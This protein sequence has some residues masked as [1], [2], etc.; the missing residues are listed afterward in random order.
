MDRFLSDNLTLLLPR[1]KESPKTDSAQGGADGKEPEV[2]RVGERFFVHKAVVDEGFGRVPTATVGAFSAAAGDIMTMEQLNGLLGLRAA[3]EMRA[4][5]KSAG[6]AETVCTRW[7]T[8][9]VTQVKHL[10]RVNAHYAVGTNAIEAG[11]GVCG[12]EFVIQPELAYL[13]CRRSRLSFV[14]M[15]AKDVLGTLLKAVLPEGGYLFSVADQDK[16]EA[17]SER[18]H[19]TQ[20]DETDYEFF[21]R[22][23]ASC[24]LTYCYR[25]PKQ[26]AEA[27]ALTVP[28][29][30]VIGGTPP[31]AAVSDIA[32]ES[33]TKTESGET[34]RV[35][36]FTLLH[37]VADADM[38]APWR[39]EGWRMA[40]AQGVKECAVSF[41]DAVGTK[42]EGRSNLGGDKG[43]EYPQESDDCVARFNHVPFDNL[44]AADISSA[45]GWYL[46]DLNRGADVW[47]GTADRLEV[48]PGTKLTVRGFY[49]SS[50]KAG[51]IPNMLVVDARTTVVSD[52]PEGVIEGG[53]VQGVRRLAVEVRCVDTASKR[54]DCCSL[55]VG[56]LG[57]AAVFGRRDPVGSKVT[58]IQEYRAGTGIGT[59]VSTTTVLD[60]DVKDAAE[61]VRDEGTVF[62][63]SQTTFVQAT[64][65]D[66][67]GSFP[68]KNAAG[69]LR[70]RTVT[71][72]TGAGAATEAKS[73]V[74]YEFYA[75][76]DGGDA[77][78]SVMVVRFVQ[79]VGGLGQGLFRVPR[80]GD[81]ILAMR[82]SPG[83]TSVGGIN[84]LVG[85][86]PGSDMKHVKTWS[87]ERKKALVLRFDQTEGMKT[88]LCSAAA[89]KT[90]D[91]KNLLSALTADTRFD[92][93]GAFRREAKENAFSELGFYDRHTSSMTVVDPK[94]KVQAFT[95]SDPEKRGALANLQSTGDVQVS[96]ND[97]IEINA[98]NIHFGA[99][100]WKTWRST[101]DKVE[102][103][104]LEIDSISELVGRAR[105][106]VVLSVDGASA[107]VIDH[108]GVA[109]R[110][111]RWNV[112]TCFPATSSSMAVSGLRG[113]EV[114]GASVNIKG[115]LGTR[116][117]DA[118]GSSLALS[119][120]TACLTGSFVREQSK[121]VLGLLGSLA[122]TAG[123]AVAFPSINAIFGTGD[124]ATSSTFSRGGPVVS[125]VLDVVFALGFKEVY[126]ESDKLT[127]IRFISVLRAITAL[128]RA[129]PM[130]IQP[131][132]TEYKWEKKLSSGLVASDVI[133]LLSMLSSLALWMIAFI[134]LTCKNVTKRNAAVSLKS[135]GLWINAPEE[136]NFTVRHFTGN[137]A[138]AGRETKVEEFGDAD[139]KRNNIDIESESDFDLELK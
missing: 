102:D 122:G 60:D 81:R 8:G 120:G 124:P 119:A 77:G 73:D 11:T 132:M 75:R 23:L 32:P 7:M 91:E 108:D 35:L 138:T 78:H 86:L 82:F 6:T 137:A 111:T 80:P 93:D 36:S 88:S 104:K 39:M 70:R 116:F 85:Y 4:L 19:F 20:G 110:S 44:R 131:M 139:S 40:Y 127:A 105:R 54:S 123:S 37:P 14:D 113:V 22:V 47:S 129:A 96:A 114:V 53:G 63:H 133:C 43:K 45:A 62:G 125:G 112:M 57:N 100:G 1:T 42:L 48:R 84:Y 15:S 16:S 3:V 101:S 117:T 130:V 97:R 49:D 12:Y 58:T 30:Y 107:L 95:E 41:G 90:E 18:R 68:T 52:I 59:T 92:A 51:D 38:D 28:V 55:P 29:L 56:R 25:M 121:T 71:V 76:P 50:V 98:R 136:Q 13:Q 87:D 89:S 61:V 33:T 134:A 21:V 46:K 66:A 83:G 128:I 10:G 26:S 9:V 31:D 69:E 135:S 99:H 34:E 2:E 65:C 109:V 103:G 106:R 17:L 67:S 74:C 64:V 126:S 5:D 27:K 79:P 94:E 72:K 118:A 24:G 115:A